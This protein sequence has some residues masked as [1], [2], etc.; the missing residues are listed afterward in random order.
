MNKI[1]PLISVITPTLNVE[2]TIG[3]TLKSVGSQSFSNIEHIIMDGA[4]GDGTIGIVSDF[5]HDHPQVRLF[6][7]KD[8]GVY[9]AMNKAM[10]VCRGDWIYFL[11]SHDEFFDDQ[12]LESLFLEG[13]FGQEAVVYGNVHVKGDAVWAG[14]DHIYDGPFD[15][16]KLLHRNICHQSIFYPRSVIG[17]IGQFNPRYSVTAD[18]DF[19]LRC[20]AKYEFRFVD[21]TI[22]Y[23]QAGGLS[24]SGGDKEFGDDKAAN[25]IRYFGI[26]P[27]SPEFDKPGSPFFYLVGVYRTKNRN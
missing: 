20:R 11:G 1:S 2:E 19:N 24:S 3:Q 25:V 21:K 26:D 16:W 18:W 14:P 27:W 15:I 10:E 8:S 9:D 12:V 7:E 6:S 22:A 13:H 17:N 5:M 4:S 23:F